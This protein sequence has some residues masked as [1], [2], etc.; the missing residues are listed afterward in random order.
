[1]ERPTAAG[2]R[3]P[4]AS[5]HLEED[6]DTRAALLASIVDSSDD[7]IISKTLAGVVTSWNRAAE[8]IYGYTEDEILGQPVSVLVGKDRPHEMQS[9]LDEIRQGRRIEHYDTVR[10]R[11]DGS[12]IPVSLTVSPIHGKSGQVI[13][14]SSIARDIS[15]SV[16]IQREFAETKN[17]LDSLLQSSIKYSIIGKDL[18]QRIVSWNEGA[19]RNYGYTADEVIG[20]P[21]AR[22]HVGADLSSGAVEKLL[23]SV[24]E[25]GIAEGEFERVRKDG[26]RFHASVVVTRR[27]DAGGKQIG[28]LVMSSDVTAQKTA[29]EQ[30]RSAS[31]YARR[32]IEASLDPL[33]TIAPTGKISDV[34]QAT[35]LATGVAREELIGTDFS[36]Y[37][38]EPS[39]ARE[40]YE[41]AFAV[42]AIVD[43]PLTIRHRD[44]GRVDVLYNVSV[45]ADEGGTPLG[46]FAAARDVTAQKRAKAELAEQRTRELERL[47]ELERFQR[48]TVGRELKMI[49]LKSEIRELKAALSRP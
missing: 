27:H 36:D 23:R 46:V 45:Y 20:Q 38:T 34:N 24:D 29:E 49:E 7:A 19:R 30:V 37:F 47:A 16:R 43:F 25:L 18:E 48:L 10:L 14:A 9:I 22:L 11:K 13:G 40:A 6:E 21:S 12:S 35:V 33:V 44:G 31:L 15:Q 26:T 8:R 1:M 39:K 42:G 41:Q 2:Y 17:L 5:G 4:R 32:L 3:A 28:Y